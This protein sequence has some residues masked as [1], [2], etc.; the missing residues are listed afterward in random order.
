MGNPLQNQLLDTV[1]QIRDEKRPTMALVVDV[2]DRLFEGFAQEAD[3]VKRFNGP[4]VWAWVDVTNADMGYEKWYVVSGS[5]MPGTEGYPMLTIRQSAAPR[6]DSW[7]S[8]SQL[9]V[10]PTVRDIETSLAMAM[11]NHQGAFDGLRDSISNLVTKMTGG[12]QSIEDLTESL[13][14]EAGKPPKDLN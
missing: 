6:L 13:K 10:G 9:I 11:T 12:R 7:V 1:R 14:D 5:T 3:Y 4:D 2:M 8:V